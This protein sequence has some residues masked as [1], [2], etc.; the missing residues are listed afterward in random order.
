MPTDASELN[1]FW[2]SELSQAPPASKPQK[3]DDAAV[4]SDNE[5][6]EKEDD[7]RTYFDE[8]LEAVPVARNKAPRTHKLSILQCLHLLES[9]RAQFTSCWL[10]LLPHLSSSAALSTRALN[11]LHR[12]VMPHMNRP[13]R[14]MDWVAGCVDFGGTACLA[15]I[16]Q[17]F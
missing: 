6:S 3:K 1:S 7:W 9:H 4:N 14:L 8:P 15:W 13:I 12:G 11:V 10:M 17:C 2:V 16:W 5:D